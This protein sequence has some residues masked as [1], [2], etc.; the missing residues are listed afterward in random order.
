MN[1]NRNGYILYDDFI[2]VVKGW[3]F[4]ASDDLMKQ[5]F[6]WLDCDKDNKISFQDLR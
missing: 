6:D 5:L 4:V 3:G 2:D 1:R